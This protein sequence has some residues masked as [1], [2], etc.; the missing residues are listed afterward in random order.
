F[1]SQVL[2]RMHSYKRI[3]S[4]QAGTDRSLGEDLNQPKLAGAGSVRSDAQFSGVVSDLDYPDGAA[5]FFTEKGQGTKPS[6]LLLAG[7]EVMDLKVLRK[8]RVDLRLHILQYR[9]DQRGRRVKVEPQPTGC[10]QRTCLGGGFAQK[11]ADRLMDKVR[12][13]V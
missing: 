8:H 4:A 3:D 5:V 1:A 11:I 2:E 10:V 7:N 13:R 6:G 9:G 12:R